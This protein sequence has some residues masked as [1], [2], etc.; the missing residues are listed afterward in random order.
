MSGLNSVVIV[1]VIIFAVVGIITNIYRF[2]AANEALKKS[3]EL[4][5]K[6][7]ENMGKLNQFL[8]E[9]AKD[10]EETMDVLNREY[11]QYLKSNPNG[12]PMGER[13][14][15]EPPSPTVID[16]KPEEPRKKNQ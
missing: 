7:Q 11:Y 9:S 6:M 2:W 16:V 4:N 8:S 13:P 14:V 15:S 12:M 1:L 5:R 3:E 10:L